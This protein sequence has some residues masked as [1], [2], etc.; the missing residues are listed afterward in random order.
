MA[1][2]DGGD[3]ITGGCAC[4]IV[5]YETSSKP[6]MS[7][8]C[9]CRDCQHDSGTGHSCHVM[10]PKASFRLSGE[11]KEY[12]SVADSGNAVFRGFC[13][14]CG[15]SVLYGSAAFP[16]AIFVTA[17]S[18]DDP[19]WFRPTMVV[20]TSSAQPWDHIEA[21]LRRFEEMPPLPG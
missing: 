8:F 13:S 2:N 5:R 16:N 4:G 10:L 12:H 3:R 21:S 15:S 6:L 9:Q 14:E 19:A 18:L 11:A 17:G 1:P 7:L 20:Y